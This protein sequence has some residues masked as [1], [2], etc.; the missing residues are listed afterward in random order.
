MA[1]TAI[2]TASCKKMDDL[3]MVPQ[4]GNPQN[5]SSV[6]TDKDIDSV[7]STA[8]ESDDETVGY[9]EEGIELP[10]EASSFATPKS[11]KQS[12][13]KVAKVKVKV[14]RQIRGSKGM[15]R[16]RSEEKKQR[17][18]KP[19]RLFPKRVKQKMSEM[20]PKKTSEHKEEYGAKNMPNDATQATV[21]ATS[22]PNDDDETKSEQPEQGKIQLEDV[23]TEKDESSEPKEQPN[24]EDSSEMKEQDIVPTKGANEAT[25]SILEQP[26]ITVS[27]VIATQ[28]RETSLPGH[29]VSTMKR[30]SSMV[31]AISMKKSWLKNEENAEQTSRKVNTEQASSKTNTYHVDN[32]S[33]ATT[34]DMPDTDDDDALS[35]TDHEE[36][37]RLASLVAE[38]EE[39]MEQ[40]MDALINSILSKHKNQEVNKVLDDQ[41][42][43]DSNIESDNDLEKKIDKQICRILPSSCTDIDFQKDAE[44]HLAALVDKFDS[45]RCSCG[46]EA[47]K[48]ATFF[49][50][51]DESME[52]LTDRLSA[53]GEFAS[54]EKDDAIEDSLKDYIA[55]IAKSL[56]MEDVVESP[57]SSIEIALK[58]GASSD[59]DFIT[60]L[61]LYK[62]NSVDGGSS[63]E[64]LGSDALE[65]YD[66]TLYG[67]EEA[68]FSEAM[69]LLKIRASHQGLSEAH[70]I[71][72]IRAEQECERI[73]VEQEWREYVSAN[74][75]VIEI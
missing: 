51:T 22:K 5:G 47:T 54:C 50:I 6:S 16:S 62:A 20:G 43:N 27:K 21:T 45:L 34:L 42:S 64:T 32:I 67:Y 71:E 15:G 74:P 39:Q 18:S 14:K 41:R 44:T 19:F 38:R 13:K 3:S 66:D 46:P 37:A 40:E 56:Q 31:L 23:V 73:R 11:D 35:V 52:V 29:N 30:L 75:N 55:D 33:K 58:N 59:G 36:E 2:P 10:I 48:L 8:Q 28:D 7:A 70:L 9:E 63:E 69:R 1:P 4:D 26:A 57:H 72:R 49:G 60:D 17:K 65:S 68:D 24:P 61:Y 25:S 12:Q 53:V